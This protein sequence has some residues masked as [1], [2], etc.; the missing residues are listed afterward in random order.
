MIGALLLLAAIAT[1]QD[2]GA[3]VFKQSCAVG[4]CHGSGGSAN[5]APRLA[6]RVFDRAK[7]RT[8]VESGIPNTAMPAFGKIL[9]AADLNAVIEYV[10]SLGT[11]TGAVNQTTVTTA[12]A[13]IPAAAQRGKDLFFDPVRGTRCGTC[14]TVEGMGTA[15]GPNLASAPRDAAAI[16]AVK[17]QHVKTASV[18]GDRFP[19]IV[20]ETKG[21]WM[22]VYDL[23][24]S[25]PVL[26]T[27]PAGDVSFSAGEWSHSRAIEGYRDDD[28]KSVADYLAWLATR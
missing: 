13:A 26:R 20:V 16:Q 28:L 8:A 23:T 22:K 18:A 21:G 10:A 11:A 17:A 5:R 15:V 3:D 27:L 1:A 19:A 2:R 6:G 25:P 4:Y 24:V 7:L 12:K 14:H 9:P